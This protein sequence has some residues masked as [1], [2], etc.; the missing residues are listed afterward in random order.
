MTS[1]ANCGAA[2]QPEPEPAPVAA[3]PAAALQAGPLLAGP[4]HPGLPSEVLPHI[5]KFLTVEEL[6]RLARTS[7]ALKEH[8][9][10][11]A[12]P[13]HLNARYRAMLPMKRA[14]FKCFSSLAPEGH[15]LTSRFTAACG[16]LLGFLHPNQRTRLVSE[17][18]DADLT[19]NHSAIAGLLAGLSHLSDAD[20]ARLIG[21]VREHKVIAGIQHW[22]GDEIRT[23]ANRAI[24]KGRLPGTAVEPADIAALGSALGSLTEIEVSGLIRDAVAIEDLEARHIAVASLCSGLKL[25]DAPQTADLNS[26]FNCLDQPQVAMPPRAKTTAIAGLGEVMSRLT[27]NQRDRL[28]ELTLDPAVS[29]CVAMAGIGRGIAKLP[30]GDAGPHVQ[31]A[32]AFVANYTPGPFDSFYEGIAVA[33]AGIGAAAEH[34]T[35]AQ[36][37]A[38]LRA[39][40]ACPPPTVAVALAGISAGMHA[41]N[42]EERAHLLA[43]VLTCP[44]Q[45]RALAI[46]GLGP[47]LAH[48]DEAQTEALLAAA[49]AAA[50]EPIDA[51]DDASI[52][53]LTGHVPPVQ[54]I[55]ALAGVATGMESLLVDLAQARRAT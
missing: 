9:A 5:G 48:L 26:L 30:A 1:L 22:D 52:G 29:P 8:A 17:A 40:L 23:A 47:Q 42:G 49:I 45:T 39:A 55:S 53:L 34:M 33:I 15:F 4:G 54:G 32:L 6:G 51:D 37:G 35:A 19:T 14:V 7:R 21:A 10:A 24:G 3:T 16:P 46:A 28:H 18:I 11:P 25:L 20:R 38:L 31:R 44:A 50:M 43:A 12:P 13:T 27:Q 36:R 2:Y 41:M